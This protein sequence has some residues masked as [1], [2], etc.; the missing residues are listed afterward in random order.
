MLLARTRVGVQLDSDMFVAPG[1]DAMFDTTEREVTKEYAMP[2]LPVHFLDRAPKD[3]GAYW[4]RYCPKGQCKWQTARWGH[5]HPTWTYWALPWIG[6]WLRR[7]FRDEVLP[8]KEGGSMAALRITDIPEDED[9]L[10]VGTWEEGGKKQWCKIDVPGPEDFSALLRSPQTDHCSKGSCGD[11]GSDRRW[12]P[13]GAAKIFYTA[14]HA[15]EPATTK[16]LVQELA[17]KHRAGRLPPPIMFKGRFFK[18]GD[19][20]RQAFPSITCII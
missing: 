11:I 16:R 15:V 4:E 6:R 18:T 10:N 20:L 19:E 7:N 9:L 14:H 5:A 12:H 3:T 2:I 1:V 17:D 8:L 13:S